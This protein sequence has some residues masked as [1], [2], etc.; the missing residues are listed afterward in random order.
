MTKLALGILAHVDA[1]KTTLC[2]GL[3]FLTGQIRS[4]GRVDHGDSH[5]D[6]H[7]L[8]RK[9]GITIFS[10]Q[11]GIRTER[12]EAELI[13]TPGHVDFST[14]AERALQILD[15]ALLIISGTDGVQAHTL[16]LWRLLRRLHVPTFIFVN[17][18]DIAHAAERELMGALEAEL[19]SACVDFSADRTSL[20][21]SAAL[22]D[23][24]LFELYARNGRLEEAELA[25]AIREERLFPCFFGSALHLSGVRE[26][27]EG[28]EK[29]TVPPVF[30]A[31]FG[32]R[33]FK[34]SRDAQGQRLTHLRVTGGEL[35]VRMSIA[36]TSRSGERKTEK[37]AGIRLYSGARYAQLERAA[38]GDTVAV[39]GLTDTYPGQGLGFEQRSAGLAAVLSPVLSYRILLPAG[40]DTQSAYRKLCELSEEDPAL[41]IE[42]DD[43]SKEIRVR[44]MGEVQIEVL[45]S[46]IKERFD[47]DARI[48]EGR[49]MY[50]ETIAAPVEGIGHFEPL[51]HY[52][53]VHL[54]LTPLEAGSGLEWG[55]R[56]SPN[57]LDRNWQRL[58]MTHI[59]EKTHRGVLTGSPI[60]D[61]RIELVAGRAHLAHTEG[62]D[63]RQA[64]YRAIRQ[65]LMK[66][67]SIL[68]EPY[69]A[70]RIELAREQLGR[71]IGDI[72]AM[73]GSFNI[74]EQEC[75]DGFAAIS[76]F[77]PVAGMRGYA[78]T[79]AAYTGGRGR[80]ML[81][82]SHYDRCTEAE[83]VIAECA[84]EP[85]RDLENTADSV[86]CAHGA[87]FTVNWREVE[88][89]MHLDTGLSR[90]RGTQEEGEQAPRLIRGNLNVDEKELEAIMLREFGPIKRPDY[91]RPE[92]RAQADEKPQPPQPPQPPRKEYLIV[93]GYNMLFAWESL[94]S[95][96]RDD[97]AAARKRLMDI[98]ANYRAF[99]NNEVVLVFDGYRVKGNAGERFDHHGLKVAYTKEN[100]TADALI[101]RLI[102]E[103]GKN[104]AVR[105]ASSDGMIQ[106]SGVRSGALRM[107]A[108][109]L[110]AEVESVN[111]QLREYML[112]LKK[113]DATVRLVIENMPKVK[114]ETDM[115][116]HSMRL[117]ARPFEMI[118][119]GSKTIELRLYDEKRRRIAVGDSIEFTHAED[120]KR[121]LSAR[122]K[123]LH[124]FKDFAELYAALPLDKCGYAEAELASASPEDM[125]EYYPLE[126]QRRFGAVGIELEAVRTL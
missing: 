51:R 57:D 1:G 34:I 124:I 82:V 105:V 87:G 7:A 4:R 115:K 13:D 16:T 76:G 23:E 85:E 83:K 78:R 20:F 110:E 80:L 74:A 46:I 54:L 30:G 71:A 104:Y 92:K 113:G 91:G 5:L 2:E 84:Y 100:E 69:Y 43:R 40:T 64:T 102:A 95:L 60:T 17:K 55:S 8:E 68:L 27:I 62:G 35:S 61:M 81:E 3:L 29:Y 9:R 89:Y 122:V 26:L 112:K 28:L 45:K 96:A 73:G 66:A 19:S 101:E 120:E 119:S 32:A 48:D 21:E 97:L 121:R 111:E 126:E 18:M 99:K 125:L 109:E 33:V 93:D 22:A 106:L 14:E 70:Y 72:R 52:A 108:R 107:T 86:F 36:Y 75:R 37:A 114:N 58:I 39:T 47:L 50:K 6:S 56:V 63:F 88:S 118:E 10:K 25:S 53:E 98:L 123:A 94:R 90:E 65:G 31:E 49:V 79:L 15:Y 41:S 67:E 38:A 116:T 103:I 11:A 42:W 44:L 59:A 12:L 117:N 77:V 24:A